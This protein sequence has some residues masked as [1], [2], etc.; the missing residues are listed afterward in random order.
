[1]SFFPNT[2]VVQSRRGGSIFCNSQYIFDDNGVLDS[3]TISYTVERHN[4]EA[5][6]L[7]G[8]TWSIDKQGKD[9]SLSTVFVTTSGQF[10]PAIA[11]I[12]LHTDNENASIEV[13]S[14]VVYDNDEIS[15]GDGEWHL[16]AGRAVQISGVFFLPIDGG[17]YCRLS[18]L[19]AVRL[20]G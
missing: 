5:I 4:G 1:M 15:D 16:V 9:L 19:T 11:M 3:D 10:V 20:V 7:T 18:D 14:R 8:D 12:D 13:Q 17:G 6:E 2:Q